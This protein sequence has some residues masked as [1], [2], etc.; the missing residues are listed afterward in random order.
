MKNNHLIIGICAV[1]IVLSVQISCTEKKTFSN[2]LETGMPPG[3]LSSYNG[4]DSN[5]KWG[6]HLVTIV[7]CNDCHTPKKMTPIGP[8]LD[9]ARWLSGHPSEMPDIVIDRKAM[10]SNGLSVTSDLTQWVGPWGISYAANLTSD[11]TGIGSWN[12]SQFIYSMRYGKLKGVPGGRDM[13][14]PMPWQNYSQMTDNELRA[15]FA[16]LKSTAPVQNLVRQ[17]LVPLSAAK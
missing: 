12:E 15:I 7:G 3:V 1:C 14:P 5:V 11:P 9:S 16:Y 17:P 10:E 6:E 13:M 4:F 2:K 8:V